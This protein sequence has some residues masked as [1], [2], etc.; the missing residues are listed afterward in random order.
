M[1]LLFNLKQSSIFI[2]LDGQDGVKG[3]IGVCGTSVLGSNPSPGPGGEEN[4]E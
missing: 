1:I 2:V 4:E 3:N